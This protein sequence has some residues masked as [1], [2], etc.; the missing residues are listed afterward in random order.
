MPKTK[1]VSTVE[2]TCDP[3]LPSPYDQIP[4]AL[5]PVSIR[6][7]KPI[8]AYLHSIGTDD[9]LQLIKRAFIEASDILDDCIG[10]GDKLP[11][12]KHLCDDYKVK[13]DPRLIDS[14]EESIQGLLLIEPVYKKICVDTTE[15]LPT[16]SRMRLVKNM[17][18]IGVLIH[19]NNDGSFIG[20][21][22]EGE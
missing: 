21:T 12:L 10:L 5:T 4:L 18:L 3:T 19:R 14:A 1:K 15:E 16:L 11:I 9:R 8:V 2:K 17:V 22:L 13:V 6:L 20:L 7:S